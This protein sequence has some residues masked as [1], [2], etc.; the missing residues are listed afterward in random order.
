MLEPAGSTRGEHVY[1][2]VLGC[3]RP[4]ED[5]QEHLLYSKRLEKD[6]VSI[7]YHK[8]GFHKKMRT[9]GFLQS[10]ED[11]ACYGDQYSDKSS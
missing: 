1:L 11:V 4:C 2:Q 6:H 7:S 9:Q 3:H 5:A 10:K 8:G